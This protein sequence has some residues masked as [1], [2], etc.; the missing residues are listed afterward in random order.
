MSDRR[1]VF[2][3]AGRGTRAHDATGG[4]PKCLL[5]IGDET[6]ISRAIRQ[7]AELG[8][9]DVHVIVG[10]A[11]AQIASEVGEKATLH[12][13]D[14]YE[15][16]NNLWTLASHVDL[17]RTAD[18]AVMFGDVIVSDAAMRALW[19][20]S[21]KLAL[22]VDRQSRLEGTMRVKK[23]R[24]ARI[25]MGKQISTA[26]SDGNYVGYLRVH[27][28][29]TD[30]LADLIVRERAEQRGRDDYFTSVVPELSRS[31]AAQFVPVHSDEWAE[32]DTAEDFAIA[33]SRFSPEFQLLRNRG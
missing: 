23:L 17:L 2:L 20:S 12:Y 10:H 16:T 9:T 26:D 30:A 11:S 33:R 25:D 31:F 13:Y 6:L 18:C 14:D 32:I 21:A 1:A 24:A 3:C 28:P 15:H 22:L 8:I 29:A 5:Q 19:N 27:G 4:V 7:L